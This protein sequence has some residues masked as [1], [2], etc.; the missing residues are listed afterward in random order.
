VEADFV[1]SCPPYADL[2]V[3]SDDPNDLS[4]LGYEDFKPAYFDIIA[5]A[6]ARP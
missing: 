5:K 6:C 4:T 3:Y 1:F 2:E